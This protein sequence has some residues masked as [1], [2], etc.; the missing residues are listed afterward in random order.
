MQHIYLPS[1]YGP[2]RFVA[3]RK[4]SN[5][6]CQ[7]KRKKENLRRKKLAKRELKKDSFLKVF[8]SPFYLTLAIVE[9][10]P[11]DKSVGSVERR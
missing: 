7:V 8:F 6:Q 9:F 5:S 10:P 2:N 4:L 1:F 11:R 3:R